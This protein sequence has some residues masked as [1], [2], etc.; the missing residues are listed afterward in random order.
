M[1]SR[2]YSYKKNDREECLKEERKK[3]GAAGSKR[4]KIRER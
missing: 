3:E 2:D 1:E 4:R